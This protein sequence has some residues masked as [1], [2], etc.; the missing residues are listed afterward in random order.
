M[1]LG[2]VVSRMSNLKEFYA[3]LCYIEQDVTESVLVGL[4]NC[5][6]LQDLRLVGNEL[7]DCLGKLFPETDMSEPSFPHLNR[8]WLN[9]TKLSQNDLQ[10][11]SH[12]LRCNKL[13]Q[14]MYLDLSLNKLT[15][16]LRSLLCATDHSGFLNL[17]NLHLMDT[18]LNKDDL[19]GIGEAVNQDWMPQLR[20]LYLDKN[21]LS[22]AETEVNNLVN[23]CT[24][25][26]KKLNL[27]I[28]FYQNKLPETFINEMKAIC[29][30]TTV[31]IQCSH[32]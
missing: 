7:T 25:K 31:W 5:K 12:S 18:E 30:G 13:P 21:D 6:N 29:K 11:I 15:G 1:G 4:A 17:R 3:K 32:Y 9:K 23:V 28:H 8:L 20:R 22:A 27:M 16:S 19:V 24:M 2:D 10:V 14:L 26:Y